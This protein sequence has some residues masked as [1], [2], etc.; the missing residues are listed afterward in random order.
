MAADRRRKLK[1]IAGRG[2]RPHLAA[3]GGNRRTGPGGAGRRARRSFRAIAAYGRSLHRRSAGTGADP[4]LPVRASPA[5]PPRRCR[6]A[7]RVER[8]PSE[9]GGAALYRSPPRLRTRR[10][11]AQS[12]RRQDSGLPRGSKRPSGDRCVQECRENKHLP[13]EHDPL[14]QDSATRQPMVGRKFFV[15]Y[16]FPRWS[17]ESPISS[18]GSMEIIHFVAYSCGNG[19]Q[20]GRRTPQSSTS[21]ETA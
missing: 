14:C 15:R 20:S 16:I 19:P 18:A 11:R 10:T 21:R 8:S 1:I 2:A 7:T 3:G 5:T 13:G 17:A 4:L 12:R 6:I 9:A